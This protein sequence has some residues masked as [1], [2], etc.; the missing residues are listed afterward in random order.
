MPAPQ[1]INSCG[2]GCAYAQHILEIKVDCLGWHRR[3]HGASK[4]APVK[5]PGYKKAWQN[6]TPPTQDLAGRKKTNQQGMGH[7]T[8]MRGFFIGGGHESSLIFVTSAR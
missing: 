1:E 6:S 8:N 4:I 5:L 3:S 2:F 7:H